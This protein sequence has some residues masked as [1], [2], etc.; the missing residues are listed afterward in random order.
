MKKSAQQK[1][2]HFVLV[3]RYYLGNQSTEGG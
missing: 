1:A 3:T 2:M